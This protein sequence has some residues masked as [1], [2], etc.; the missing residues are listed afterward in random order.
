ERIGRLVHEPSACKKGVVFV[1]AVIAVDLK[2]RARN[3]QVIAARRI[4]YQRGRVLPHPEGLAA[5]ARDMQAA[6]PRL[7]SGR[8]RC[9]SR[10]WRRSARRLRQYFCYGIGKAR[11]GIGDTKAVSGLARNL[12]CPGGR[13]S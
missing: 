5:I 6:E 9:G 3:C 1:Q 13:S 2:E 4:S 7:L 11:N 8:W 12:T 10:W